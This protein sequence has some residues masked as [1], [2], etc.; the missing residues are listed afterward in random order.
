MENSHHLTSLSLNLCLV[1]VTVR[2]K[3]WENAL[4]NLKPT[5][6]RLDKIFVNQISDK[7]PVSRMYKELLLNSKKTNNPTLKYAKD[8]NR[9]FFKEDMQIAKKKKKAH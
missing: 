1:I 9:H 7:G 2:A 5:T 6:H 8:S 4:W 3:R